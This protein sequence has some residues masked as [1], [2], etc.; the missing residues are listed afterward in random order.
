MSALNPIPFGGL[1]GLYDPNLQ[2]I[3]AALNADDCYLDAG[4]I[5]GRN[6]YRSVL[7]AAVGGSNTPQFIGRFRPSASSARTVTVSGGH[8]VLLDDP[9]SETT[10]DGTQANLGQIFG[11]PDKISGAALGT[12]YYL[13]TDDPVFYTMYRIDS[14]YGLTALIPIPAGAI[15]TATPNGGIPWSTFSPIIPTV[16][17]CVVQN[18]TN[19]GL[20]A[21]ATGW[22]AFTKTNNGNDDPVQGAY[23]Y[24]KLAAAFD[25]TQ[26]DW[27]AV[28][29][30]PHTVGSDPAGSHKI[31]IQVAIDVAGSPGTWQQ[32]GDIYD[33]PLQGGSPNAIFLDLRTLTASVRSAIQ[34]IGFTLTDSYG[35]KFLLYGYMFL[36]SPPTDPPPINYYVDFY[37][38]A[39]GMQSDLTPVLTVQTTNA[40]VASYPDSYMNYG[41]PASTG[42]QDSLFSANSQRVFNTTA[43]Q[44][45][46]ILAEV[47]VPLT[48]SGTAPIFAS[49]ASLTARLWKDTSNGRRLVA[50]ETGV[51]SGGSY[52]FTDDGGDTILSNQLYKAGGT[53]P[54]LQALSAHAGRLVGGNGQRV[55]ISSYTAPGTGGT[56]PIPQWPAIALEDADGWAFDIYPSSLEQIQCVNGE[57]DS[58]YILTQETVYTL[59]DL[60]PGSVPYLVYRRGA[61]GRRAC[62]YAEN[63]LFWCSYDGVYQAENT[64]N[65]S[66]LTQPVRSIYIDWLNPDSSVTIGYQ[67]RKLYIFQGQKFLRYDFV[68]GNWTRG[69][70]GDTVGAVGFWMGLVSSSGTSNVEQLW[71]FTD[72]LFV[73]RWQP[74]AVRDMQIGTD[75][76][77]GKLIPDWLFST[78]FDLTPAPSVITGLLLDTTEPIFVVIAKTVNGVQPEEARVLYAVPVPAQDEV[79]IAGSSDFRAQKFRF[80]FGAAN[81]TTLRRALFE[82]ELIDAKGG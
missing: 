68:L 15:P 44:A 14:G 52:T 13:T 73:G 6:G 21:L 58:V 54:I 48:I 38:P 72:S 80:Q 77:T 81:P 69:T 29:I 55:Y 70:L 5:V 79:W 28:A 71:L 64:S 61:L 16:S 76:T 53:A 31:S 82:R 11:T 33:T 19:T 1:A 34:W 25:A 59:S 63:K 10:S 27:L 39:S 32:L 36:P 49:Y 66:E 74:A 41:E 22:V 35:G 67:S 75:V 17:G 20:S 60:T 65:V 57:G 78:G 18:N 46:P 45:L 43:G 42:G 30:S 8:L 50:S 47:G 23:A 9:S 4:S 26:D 7:P 3:A 12:N 2:P 24:Y 56:N 40:T 51:T 37:D 62:C